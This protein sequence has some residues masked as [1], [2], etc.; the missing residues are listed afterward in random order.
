MHTIKS[1]NMMMHKNWG[2][3]TVAFILLIVGGLNWG[4][5]A[6]FKTDI[7]HWVGGMDS[8]VAKII[9]VLVALGALYEVFTHGWRCRECKPDGHMGA[10]SGMGG[11]MQS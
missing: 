7:G 10:G 5:L 8:T 6:L 9:Y 1:K 2:V 4:L 11:G 3:H